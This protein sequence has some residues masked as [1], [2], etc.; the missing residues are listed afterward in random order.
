MPGPKRPYPHDEGVFTRTPGV[1]DK[2]RLVAISQAG[3]CTSS[4]QTTTSISGHINHDSFCD[5]TMSVDDPSLVPCISSPSSGDLREVPSPTETTWT[6]LTASSNTETTEKWN[7]SEEVEVCFGMLVNGLLSPWKSFPISTTSGSK[8]GALILKPRF[9]AN[10]IT[11]LNS[12][13]QEIG[14]LDNNTASGMIVLKKAIS[15]VRFDIYACQG[16][17][18]TPS[19]D[20]TLGIPL[21]ILVFGPRNSLEQV[22]SLLSQSNLFLQVPIDR[23]FS[24]SYKNPHL[25][26]WDGEEDDTNSSYLLEPSSKSQTDFTEKIQAVLNDTAVPPLSFQVEQDARITSTLKQHQLV[27]L[28]FMVCREG[29][30]ETDRLTLWRPVNR[31]GRQVFRNEITHSTKILE[32]AECRGGILADEMGMGK[33]LSLLALIIYTLSCQRSHNDEN[34]YLASQKQNMRSTATLIIAPKSSIH[35]IQSLQRSDSD[36]S[37]QQYKA[38]SNKS[39]STRGQACSKF[40]STMGTDEES[41]ATA[42]LNL[43]SYLQHTKLQPPMLPKPAYLLEHHGYELSWMK[44]PFTAHQIRNRSTKNFQEL[45]KLRAERRWC[46]TGTPVQ[47]KL[48][49]LFSLTQFLGFIP[50][51]N[52][53][54]ARKYILEPLS[55]RDPG[56][57]ENLRLALQTISLRRTKDLCSARRKIEAIE[58]VILNV[59]ERRCYNTTRAEAKKALGSA[60]GKSQGE[61]LLRAISTLRQICSHGGAIIDDTPDIQRASEHNVCDKCDHTIDTQNDSQQTFHRACGHNVCYECAIYEN[62]SENTS[63]CGPKGCSVCQEPVMSYL[64][65]SQRWDGGRV[66]STLA[67]RNTNIAVTSAINSSKI[68]KVVAHLQNLEQSSPAYGMDPIKSL[69]F[70]HWNRTLNCLEEALSYNGQRYARID[71][72]LSVEQRRIVIHQFNT[73]PEIRILLLSYGAGSVGLNLQAATHVHLLEPHWNP[74]VEAQAAARVDRLDQLKDVYIYRYIVK[75][76]IEE[77][78]QNTQRGKLQDTE[79]SV[80]R[81]ATGEDPDIDANN[82]MASLPPLCEASTLLI[83][84]E[85]ERPSLRYNCWLGDQD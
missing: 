35:M 72:S 75:D 51:E 85:L 32:P 25:F 40:M 30:V 68:E 12:A 44:L 53:A 39:T 54:N 19:Q 21:E 77:Q 50:L 33:S 22:G 42:S 16:T 14:V 78:I 84:L 66:N 81:M 28:K 73:V 43:T 13:I 26:S 18:Q 23:Q 55:R 56:G 47:N 38:G 67:Y 10:G 15:S 79:L 1:V 63:N 58:Q 31:N 59:R 45:A 17:K 37:M 64:D 3:P 76:S 8:L 57:L 49:D 41:L 62:G 24:V 5:E 29:L 7:D 34:G 6:P 20:G 52:H 65:N 48:S 61:I 71:G 60:T 83:V 2:R 82:P 46:L 36:Q 27:A 80:S 69:I 9:R 11:I 74:M 70:S 4:P